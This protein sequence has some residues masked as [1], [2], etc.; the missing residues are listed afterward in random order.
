MTIYELIS[1]LI[2]ESRQKVIIYEVDTG[3]DLFEGYAVDIPERLLL[4]EVS[5]IDNIKKGSTT[6]TIN[7]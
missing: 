6:I 1:L 2:N 4:S 5:S 3:R 7:I